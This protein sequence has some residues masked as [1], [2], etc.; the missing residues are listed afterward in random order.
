MQ[1]PSDMLHPA[2]VLERRA[3]VDEL[4]AG[5][6]P[7]E[8]ARRIVAGEP[9][10]CTALGVDM[11][12]WTREVLESAQRP[13]S[14]SLYLVGSAA[15]GFSL[16]PQKAGREFRM[17]GLGEGPSDLDVAMVDPGLFEDSWNAMIHH[18]VVGG[19]RYLED[20][21]RIRVYWGRID[22]RVIPRRST[23]RT[24]ARQVVDAV[25]RSKQFRGYPASLR[26][27]RRSDDL[28]NYMTNGLRVLQR[29]LQG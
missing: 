10:L 2:Q 11:A 29:S 27:Y 16:S 15:V 8:L 23:P 14:A 26:V 28:I 22:D 19:P 13:L 9:W 17:A 21:H 18:E 24:R 6:S 1:M 5:G 25:R 7:A 4:L 20:S 12:E 3:R